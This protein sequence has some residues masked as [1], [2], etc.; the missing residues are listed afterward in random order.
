MRT[1]AVCPMSLCTGLDVSNVF[2]LIVCVVL[3]L[4]GFRD[5]WLNVKV[6]VSC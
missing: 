3:L 4:Y 6:S 5:Q 1:G 2:K